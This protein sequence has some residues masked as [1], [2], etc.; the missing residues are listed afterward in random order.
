MSAARRVAALATRVFAP[1]PIPAAFRNHQLAR[2]LERAG[3]RTAVLTTKPNSADLPDS[4]AERRALLAG[5]D[6]GISRVSRAPVKRDRAGQVRG[7][8]SYL[9]FDLPLFVRLL[10]TRRLDVI[11]AEPPPTTGV[12]VMVA[13]AIRRVPYVFYAA[14]I[15]ADATESVEGV[16]SL[17]RRIVRW[18]ETT[19]WRRAAVV[20]T[21]S[22]G[23]QA[24]IEELI[25]PTP[26][27]AMI[28]N[29]IDTETFTVDGPVAAEEGP[30]LVYAGT[31]SEWQGADVL[32]EAFALARERHPGLRLLFFSEGT[33]KDALV[34]LVRRRSLSGIEFRPRV[35][36][37]EVAAYL[38]GAVAG[39]SSIT[40]GAGYDFALPTKIYAAGACGVPI[41]HAGSPGGAA[42][43]RIREARLG[44]APGA[45]PEAIAEAMVQAV[46]AHGS[47]DRA[48]LREWTLENASLQASADRAAARIA[49]TVSSPRR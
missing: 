22:D 45:S 9:S 16:P 7:Y 44:Y 38:R 18:C 11:I 34:E 46:D 47:V 20:L 19:V 48:A 13:A 2:A 14:D 35:G 33:G 30:Y 25:G 28:S 31:V 27:L 10:V 23:V 26:T 3:M 43:Q 4:E 17:V 21:I 24:R 32:V 12:V 15:W 5:C 29:G 40:P 8:V 1:E 42:A 49:Q 36:A 6:A 41:I 37:A 39:L